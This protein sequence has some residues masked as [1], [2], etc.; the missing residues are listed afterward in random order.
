[1]TTNHP[2]PKPLSHWRHNKGRYFLVLTVAN[3]YGF[4]GGYPPIVPMVVCQGD[5]GNTWTLPLS[6]WHQSFTE[7]IA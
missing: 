5:D 1:M 6:E 4:D 3:L 2:I 7:V